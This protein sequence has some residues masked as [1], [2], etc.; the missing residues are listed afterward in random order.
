MHVIFFSFSLGAKPEQDLKVGGGAQAPR[1]EEEGTNYLLQAT[2]QKLTAVISYPQAPAAICQLRGE[3][4]HS[5]GRLPPGWKYGVKSSLAPDAWA[6]Q[7]SYVVARV[8]V[9]FVDTRRGCLVSHQ[10]L[11]TLGRSNNGKNLPSIPAHVCRTSMLRARE[12]P[13]IVTRCLAA[14]IP[15]DKVL[16]A[17][18]D[19][20]LETNMCHS[21]FSCILI[22]YTLI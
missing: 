7:D 14:N 20:Y 1:G 3:C 15:N 19:A 17:T 18:N 9:R 6:K 8:F 21:F 12:K 2:R 22:Y 4:K 11:G 16:V 13:I 10:A 5:H